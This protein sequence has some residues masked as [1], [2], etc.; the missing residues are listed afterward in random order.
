VHL[1]RQVAVGRQLDRVGRTEFESQP[2]GGRVG[3][4][5]DDPRRAR[6]GGPDHRRQTH[7][8]DAH[9]EYGLAHRDLGPV[10]RRPE[11]G[12]QAAGGQAGDLERDAG[13]DLDRVPTLDH[14][15]LGE[16][17]LHQV[18]VDRL[19]GLG[20]S[21]LVMDQATVEEVRST[22]LAQPERTQLALEAGAAAGRDRHDDVIAHG[23][24]GDIGANLVDHPRALVTKNGRKRDRDVA[25]IGVQVVPAEATRDQP[26]AHLARLGL[27][28][29]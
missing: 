5:H 12:A 10:D 19:A 13:V 3:V 28:K 7:P 25:L 17:R 1:G 6:T 29:V 18:V 26:D 20:Q 16:R 23:Q 27:G 8:A 2:A 15:V 9:N 22:H 4:G 11:A 24:V 21:P 14:R